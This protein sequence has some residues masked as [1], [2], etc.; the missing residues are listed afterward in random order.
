M[1]RVGSLGQAL[2]KAFGIQQSI[3]VRNGK[4]EFSIPTCF[5]LIERRVKPL[6]ESVVK[7]LE[8]KKRLAVEI[9]KEKDLSKWNRLIFRAKVKQTIL[10]KRALYFL[11]QAWNIRLKREKLEK[12]LRKL[13][14]KFRA[15]R[16]REEAKRIY[17]IFA[18]YKTVYYLMRNSEEY[19][20]K[21]AYR[22]IE[23]AEKYGKQVE[24]FRE[25]TKK[26]SE[27]EWYLREIPG[28]REGYGTRKWAEIGEY[29]NVN[30]FRVHY[31]NY[32]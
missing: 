7:R 1:E 2:L 29:E 4:W 17:P 19:Y 11:H 8:E 22:F 30:G 18:K 6:P 24:N 31:L 5:E 9:A 15:T 32:V 21:V 3:V 26:F 25:F 12:T 10:T 14:R 13:E 16:S 20:R 23:L 27:A 28:I